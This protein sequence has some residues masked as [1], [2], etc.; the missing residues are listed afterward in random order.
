MIKVNKIQV[1]SAKTELY[2]TDRDEWFDGPDLNEARESHSSCSHGSHVYV[3]GGLGPDCK[4]LDS[5]EYF[6]A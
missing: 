1:V 6:N 4:P 3:F 5:I 2:S